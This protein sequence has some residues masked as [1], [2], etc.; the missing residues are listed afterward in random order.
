MFWIPVLTI[1]FWIKT[2]TTSTAEFPGLSYTNIESTNGV[3]LEQ[4]ADVKIYH[5]EWKLVTAINLTHFSE[6]MDNLESALNKIKLVCAETK[7]YFESH[8]NIIYCEKIIEQADIMLKDSREYNT[9][10]FV[11]NS[12]S[13]RR[14]KRGLADV[15]GS[16]A[17]FL[18]GVL[19]EDDGKMYSEM[20]QDLQL[21]QMEQR[22]ISEKQTTLIK[23]S[24]ENMKELVS[25]H[26]NRLNIINTEVNE[27]KKLLYLIRKEFDRNLEQ[28]HKIANLQNKLNSLI[29]LFILYMMQFERKQSM[30]LEAIATGQKSP[31]S[32]V[33]IPPEIL[34]IELN[35]ILSHI[36][37]RKLELHLSITPQN[38]PK[39]YQ[40]SAPAAR[41][42]NNTLFVSFSI[43]LVT[44]KNFHLYKATSFPYSINDSD[45]F[46]FIVPKL[47]Y[48]AID[49][50]QYEFIDI[51]LEHLNN[52]QKL[53]MNNFVCK[54]EFPIFPVHLSKLCEINIL[55][56][57]NTVEQCDLRIF[58]MINEL[59]IKIHKP[60]TYIF[61][62]PT[63]Q[64]IHIKCANN[65]K[66]LNVKETG[67]ITI[68]PGCQMKSNGM[69][70]SGFETIESQISQTIPSSASF[71]FNVSNHINV[72]MGIPGFE[73]PSIDKTEL[74][75]DADNSKL[76]EISIGIQEMKQM[77]E[78]FAKK[79]SPG[80]LR[81]NISNIMIVLIVIG[82][83]ILIII[84]KYSY[85]KMSKYRARNESR[86]VARNNPADEIYV[87]VE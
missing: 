44:M 57:T 45:I 25:S 1:F 65:N 19:S 46:A 9:E 50:S 15:V 12:K 17:K 74:I 21:K 54:Q 37:I 31:N 28:Q 52:C 11:E 26:E 86:V 48:F 80:I 2:S 7:K 73:I 81:N 49:T 6:E 67:I 42:Y 64:N 4:I 40:I 79:M 51:S 5:S 3:F 56:E 55:M 32:P 68:P 84:I 66:K 16:S 76:K 36:K 10:W 33:V 22:V 14:T 72:L 61:A 87:V 70:I 43:P 30:F 27:I 58:K 53:S 63:K 60:N 24:F 85:K 35:K 69:E 77:E 71:V 78:N 38:L 75:G 47:E 18:F 59:W 83:V 13:K 39:Y 62:L 29:D 23:T 20:F 41:I 34:R 8:Q 82:L